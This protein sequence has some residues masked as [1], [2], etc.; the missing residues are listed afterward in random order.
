MSVIASAGLSASSQVVALLAFAIMGSIAIIVP[1]VVH[2]AGG[3]RAAGVLARWKQIL[4]A[5]NPVIMAVLLL[6][7]GMVLIGKGIAQIRDGRRWPTWNSVRVHRTS[8][9]H[10]NGVYA[11]ALA[12]PWRA[13]DLSLRA[14]GAYALPAIF[15]DASARAALTA[16]TWLSVA[17]PMTF[18]MARATAASMVS[19]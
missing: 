15:A 8:P 11:P 13:A 12:R 3:D 14:V 1:V 19:A 7:F 10:G 17:S 5:N 9:V 18:L 6:V 16:F 2:F 4:V